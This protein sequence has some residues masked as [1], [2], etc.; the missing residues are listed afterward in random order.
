MPSAK[1]RADYDGL[2]QFVSGFNKA[3][4]AAQ[5]SLQAVAREKDVLQN[6]DWIGVGATAFYKEMD[7]TVL[8]TLRRLVGAL[9]FAALTTTEISGIIKE[10]EGQAAQTLNGQG[11]IGGALGAAIGGGVAGLAEGAAGAAGG[12]GAAAGAVGGA[13]GGLGA[14]GAAIAGGLA[15]AAGAAGQAVGGSLGGLGAGIGEALGGASGQAGGLGS[16]V[17]AAVGAAIGGAM[18]GQFGAAIGAA[19]G[20]AVGSQAFSDAVA[21][22]D[23]VSDGALGSAMDNFG[24]FAQGLGDDVVPPGFVDDTGGVGPVLSTL[25]SPNVDALADQVV[26]QAAGGGSSGGGGGDTGGGGS[27]GGGGGGGG[28]SGGAS[29]NIGGFSDAALKSIISNPNLS[30]QDKLLATAIQAVRRDPNAFNGALS[31]FVNQAL[32]GGGTGAAGGGGGAAQAAQAAGGALKVLD[33]AVQSAGTSSQS[34]MD[35]ISGLQSQYNS[36]VSSG[37]A[38]GAPLFSPPVAGSTP[39]ASTSQAIMGLVQQITATVD[40]IIPR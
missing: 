3:T 33:G 18:G 27:S 32:A 12:I 22:L 28:P 26:G 17:G 23:G 30:S 16:A 24:G 20:S 6:G 37:G 5:R 21:S 29:P 38:G 2:K 14:A 25:G 31:N 11:G 39:P 19:V 40:A 36:I 35:S 13:L 10:A 4:E 34:V 9:S 7:D 15:G 1:V 8:P